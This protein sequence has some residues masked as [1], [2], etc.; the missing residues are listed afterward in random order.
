MPDQETSFV[1]RWSRRKRA[2]RARR[3]SAVPTVGGED[4]EAT[5]KAVSPASVD[6]D[7]QSASA[8]AASGS[9]GETPEQAAAALPAIESLDKDSD[10]TVFLKEG[11]PEELKTLALRKLWRSDP[12]FARIDGLDDYDEDV[13][14]ILARGSELIE[15]AREA[16]GKLVA[17][18][19]ETAPEGEGADQTAAED[20][21]ETPPEGGRA[22]ARA[23]PAP[24]QEATGE[25]ESAPVAATD[26]TSPAPRPGAPGK[27]T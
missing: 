3:N 20:E 6:P 21:P 2:Q 18:K 11:V 15:K 9:R 14:A 13:K 26:E 1:R 23:R 10:F 19:D 5:P 27:T 17:P 25:D 12:V 22:T 4:G 8:P 7:A 16:G 24:P